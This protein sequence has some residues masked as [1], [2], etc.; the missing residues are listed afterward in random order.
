MKK[1]IIEDPIQAVNF[2]RL[3]GK[4]IVAYQCKNSTNV[5]VLARLNQGG[6]NPPMKDVPGVWFGFVP[7]G[8]TQGTP[9]FVGKS[10]G[11]S[12]KCAME[13]REV[14]VFDNVRDLCNWVLGRT[15]FNA[16]NDN[17]R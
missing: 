4:E 1:I 13:K 11:E 3:Q 9:R 5:A 15:R 16:G 7:L 10:F 6:Y 14:F 8:E 17:G 2:D 12:I